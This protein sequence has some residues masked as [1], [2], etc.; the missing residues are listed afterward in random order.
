MQGMQ[1][2]KIAPYLA[3]LALVLSG[4]F[5]IPAFSQTITKANWVTPSW[6]GYVDENGKGLYFDVISAVYEPEGIQ[7]T[8]NFRPWPR[9]LFEVENG[10]ADFTGADSRTSKFAQPKTPILRSPEVVFLRKAA[11][12]SYRNI[13]S[14]NKKSGVWVSGY[15]DNLPDQIKKHLK[16]KGNPSRDAAFQM[17]LL[18]RADYFLDNDYQLA[19]T[20]NKFAGKFDTSE[21]Q[22]ATV[23][24]EDLY[25]CFTKSQRGQRLADI[26]DQRMK[27]LSDAGE[28]KRIYAKWNRFSP[29]EQFLNTAIP[30]KHQPPIH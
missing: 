19:Q 16:G 4:I 2:K 22:V 24:S 26:F 30:K 6:E 27:K 14:L 7:I 21:F 25:M 12:P 1:G 29:A 11:I 13:E 20:M 5:A 3:Y 17:V 28:L 10:L 23:Y 9:A 18:G 15:T 8:I